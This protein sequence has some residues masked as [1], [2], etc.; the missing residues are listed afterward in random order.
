MDGTPPPS[1]G[2][3][4]SLTLVISAIGLVF[5]VTNK[6]FHVGDVLLSIARH[7]IATVGG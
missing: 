2:F 5:L 1:D 6:A 7:A 3:D 4:L